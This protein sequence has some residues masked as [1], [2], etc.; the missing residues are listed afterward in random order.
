MFL[1][2]KHFK[3]FKRV[4]LTVV[5]ITDQ[6][7]NLQMFFLGLTWK[8]SMRQLSDRLFSFEQQCGLI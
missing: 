2:L 5:L 1:T 4:D 6:A 3:V 7:T 8:L